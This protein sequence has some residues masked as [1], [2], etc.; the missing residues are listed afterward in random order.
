MTFV[1]TNTLQ[2]VREHKQQAAFTL[3]LPSK[4]FKFFFVSDPLLTGFLTKYDGGPNRSTSVELPSENRAHEK[5][6]T[7]NKDCAAVGARCSTCKKLTAF[8]PPRLFSLI[9]CLNQHSSLVVCMCVTQM[10]CGWVPDPWWEN[11]LIV[12]KCESSRPS[13]CLFL[14]VK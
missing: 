3:S 5:P 1:I 8:S 13:Y 7:V 12:F 2:Y 6:P 9:C 4:D 14:W 10:W 11:V